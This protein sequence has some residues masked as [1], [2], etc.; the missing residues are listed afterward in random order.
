[1]FSPL[2]NYRNCIRLSCGQRWTPR[3]ERAIGILSCL[4]R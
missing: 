2:Q 3:I 1:M 4:V